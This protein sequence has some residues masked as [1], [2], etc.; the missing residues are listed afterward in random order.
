MRGRGR[1]PRVTRSRGLSERYYVRDRYNLLE[2]TLVHLYIS[3][4]RFHLSNCL[5][6]F[7]GPYKT[8]KAA[9]RGHQPSV[10]SRIDRGGHQERSYNVDL[11][12]T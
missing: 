10:D 5:P 4:V 12:G 11:H 7:N 3:L 6:R 8:L 9:N 2:T 1:E